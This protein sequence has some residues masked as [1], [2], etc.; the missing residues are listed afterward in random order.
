MPIRAQR[1]SRASS[2]LLTELDVDRVVAIVTATMRFLMHADASSVSQLDAAGTHLVLI[3]GEGLSPEYMRSVRI[4]L[5]DA[6]RLYRGPEQ[7]LV[8]DMRSPPLG[9]P[10]AIKREGLAK[11]IAFPLVQRGQFVGAINAYL[12][13]PEATFPEENLDLAHVLAAEASIALTNAQIFGELKR[14]E[15]EKEQ[16]LA[17]VSHELR[18]PLTPL[19]A[20]AQLLISRIRRSRTGGQ[21]LDLDSLERNLAS[22][23]RQVDRMNG[24]VSDLLSVSRA[25][26]GKLELDQR[27]FD[28]AVSV[29]DMVERYAQATKEADGRHEF[30]VDSPKSFTVYGD[31]ARVEQ[32]LMNLIGNAVK[33]SP[34]GG[35]VRVSL[36]RLDGAAEIAI[37]DEGIGIAAEDLPRLGTAFTRGSGKAGTFAGMGIGLHVAKLLAEA[38]G[39]ELKLES[40]G[41]DRGT[42]VRV[43]LPAA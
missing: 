26:R 40:P 38:H 14:V 16:F 39:G 15:E 37:A 34:R 22:I 21:P 31:Q 36:A 25:E 43:R 41:E 17:I 35:R 18:T 19:K 23:E 28:L 3:G 2:E 1:L 11:V 33:Y 13:D 4:P 8:F 9:D 42:T 5:A 7:H 30:A 6:R 12:R 10:A 32:L 24:L 20:L 29:R 27:P